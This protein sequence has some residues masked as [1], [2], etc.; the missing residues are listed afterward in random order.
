VKL[1]GQGEGRLVATG[2]SSPTFR[3]IFDI[4]HTSRNTSDSRGKKM[5]RSL[6]TIYSITREDGVEIPFG[7]FDL[8]GGSEFLRCRHSRG[9]PEWLVLS[10]N[11]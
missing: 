2:K 5:V 3:V 10:S 1:D 9:N 8:L 6:A 11:A 7:D 4:R